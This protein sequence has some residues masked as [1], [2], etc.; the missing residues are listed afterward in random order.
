MDF[1]MGIPPSE[2]TPESVVER[3]RVDYTDQEIIDLLRVGAEEFEPYTR[4]F[5]EKIFNLVYTPPAIELP[6][7]PAPTV[8][9]EVNPAGL[10]PSTV[11]QESIIFTPEEAAQVFAPSTAQNPGSP[12]PAPPVQTA[13]IPA[14]SDAGQFFASLKRFRIADIGTDE[15]GKWHFRVLPWGWGILAGVAGLMIWNR[16]KGKAP[17]RRAPVRRRKKK[18]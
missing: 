4:E 11:I 13:E 6:G 3:L 9:S 1:K 14:G 7:G 10:D 5:Q 16:T 12:V 8:T 18:K 2:E 17:V 15:S